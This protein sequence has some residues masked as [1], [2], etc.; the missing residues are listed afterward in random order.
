MLLNINEDNRFLKN[1]MLY[2]QNL[3][4]RFLLCLN[5]LFPFFERLS[6][7][8]QSKIKRLRVYLVNNESWVILIKYWQIRYLRRK[9]SILHNANCDIFSLNARIRWVSCPSSVCNGDMLPCI[10]QF[11]KF[12]FFRTHR[13]KL[14]GTKKQRM[15]AIQT[16]VQIAWGFC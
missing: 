10:I 5:I 7:F 2:S 1:S 12:F 11:T 13:C 4:R 3:Y 16:M 15:G 6:S 8:C 14:P 9:I